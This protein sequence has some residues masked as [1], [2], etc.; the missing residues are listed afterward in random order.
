[1]LLVL[2]AAAAPAVPGHAQA[3]GPPPEAP[4]MAS[5][6][7]QSFP[8]R[9]TPIEALPLGGQAEILRLETLLSQA[10]GALTASPTAAVF[11]PILAEAVA[12]A[13]EQ[14]AAVEP[15]WNQDAYRREAAFYAAEEA[16]RHPAGA[17]RPAPAAPKRTGGRP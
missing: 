6:R 13:A 12:Q 4:A 9:R 1:M 17:P 3:Q 5:Y 11:P 8:Q 15:T 14:A 7:G 2:L 10:Y 16:R